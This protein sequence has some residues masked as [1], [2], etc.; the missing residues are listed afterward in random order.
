MIANVRGGG[1]NTMMPWDRQEGGP[2]PSGQN[3]QV[4]RNPLKRQTKKDWSGRSLPPVKVRYGIRP[5]GRDGAVVIIA[6]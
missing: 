6:S 1:V 3:N 4:G 5:Q 2:N